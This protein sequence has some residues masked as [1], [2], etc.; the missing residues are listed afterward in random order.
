MRYLLCL[1]ILASVVGCQQP[2][3]V[4]V[5]A[6]NSQQQ[7]LQAS[8]SAMVRAAPTLVVLRLGCSYTR[9]TPTVAKQL[10]EATGRKLMNAV[11]KAGVPSNEIQTSDF[12]LGSGYDSDQKLTNWTCTNLLEIR[13]KE[14][15]KASDI[16]ETALNAGANSVQG[17]DYTI[18]ELQEL[19]AKARDQACQVAKAKA[20]QLAR[21]FGAKLG[22]PLSISEDYPGGWYFSR[23]TMS[24]NVACVYPVESR[25]RGSETILSGGSVSVELRVDVTYAIE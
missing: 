5:V 19:R 13:I 15:A 4:T 24:Q 21:N 18:E 20:E 17:I 14:V 6:P 7:G 22:K 2:P 9:S 8:G 16:L 25:G 10:A 11:R 3:Q 12:R 23:N 1:C